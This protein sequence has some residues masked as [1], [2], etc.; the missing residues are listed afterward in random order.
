LKGFYEIIPQ[1]LISIFTAQEL[2]LLICGLPDIDSSYFSN[3]DKNNGLIIFE[4]FIF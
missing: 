4:F 2:E 3:C 1:D